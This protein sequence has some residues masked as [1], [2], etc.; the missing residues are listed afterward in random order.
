M[1][2]PFVL[3]GVAAPTDTK[4]PITAKSVTENLNHRTFFA[5]ANYATDHAREFVPQITSPQLTTAQ[6]KEL[7]K[8][9][10]RRLM[11]LISVEQN[12]N[13]CV[14]QLGADECLRKAITN[15]ET[16]FFIAMLPGDE[17]E[18]DTSIYISESTFP[19]IFAIKRKSFGEMMKATRTPLALVALVLFIIGAVA[20]GAPN[21]TDR[22]LTGA[23]VS[24]VATAVLFL[25]TVGTVGLVSALTSEIDTERHKANNIEIFIARLKNVIN[26]DAYRAHLPETLRQQLADLVKTFTVNKIPAANG[27]DP[28]A[29]IAELHKR[30]QPIADF[31][32]KVLSST[33]AATT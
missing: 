10:L 8:L 33:P 32:H 29:E 2:S 14:P 16:S 3:C 12:K 23:I 7:W 13:V 18:P 28:Q 11:T 30:Y 5:H 6:Q 4:R 17:D 22:A 21:K 15:G 24:L 31:Y 20:N 26:K 9:F 1:F 27:A 25:L 19:D